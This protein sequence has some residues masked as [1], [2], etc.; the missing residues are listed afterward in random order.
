MSRRGRRAA[1]GVLF[2]CHNHPSLHPGGTEVASHGLFRELRDRHGVEGAFLG[3]VDRTHRGALPGTLLQAVGGAPDEILLWT[4]HFD[5]FNLSQIDLH[6]V[7][8]ELEGLLR[9]VKPEVV[10]FHHM[11]MIGVEAFQVV[12]RTLPDAAILLTLHD[13]YPI[14]ANDGQMTTPRLDLCARAEPDACARCLP[15]VARDGFVMRD[16]FIRHALSFVD[17]FIAPSAFLKRRYV[18]W[19]LPEA[20]IDVARNGHREDWPARARALP[21][22]GSR[23]RFAFFGNINPYKGALVALQAARRLADGGRAEPFSLVLHGDAQFQSEAFKADLAA[24]AKAAEPYARLAGPYARENLGGLIADADWVVVPSL[25]WENAPLVVEEAFLHRR[26]VIC[27]GIGGMAEAVRDGVDGL[28]VRPNDP[29]HLAE[30]M[31]E[32]MDPSL[33]ERLAGNIQAPRTLAQAADEH[34]DIYRKTLADRAR[35]RGR[36]QEAHA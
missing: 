12:R 11:L 24:A 7:V 8:P 2:I 30:R 6:A 29:G 3:C 5:R 18:E 35:G 23:S 15:D 4:G 27:S 36:I 32:A 17:R 14:C 22:G 19:G 13:Y 28:W 9:A 25:W 1:P 33:W 20:R 34:L 31:R 21:P 26:P 16:L 10:H